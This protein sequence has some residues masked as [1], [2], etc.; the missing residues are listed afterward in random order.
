VLSNMSA[1]VLWPHTYG[2]S[3]GIIYRGKGLVAATAPWAAEG[4]PG[5]VVV[6]TPLWVAAH[7]THFTGAAPGTW[8]LLNGTGSGFLA[9]AAVGRNV[10]YVT[11]VGPPPQP[12]ADEGDQRQ[13][14]RPGRDFTLVVESMSF[15]PLH[16]DD[17][18]ADYSAAAAAAAAA[19]T[20]TATFQ[21]GGA[22]AGWAGSRLYVWHTNTTVTFEPAGSVAVGADGTFTLDVEPLAVYTVTTV[23]SSNPGAA[24]VLA[25]LGPPFAPSRVNGS[26]APP[27]VDAPFPL[28]WADDYEGYANDSLPLY[29]SDMFGAF[30]TWE[31]TPAEAA[32]VEPGAGGAGSSALAAAVAGAGASVLACADGVVAAAAAAAAGGPASAAARPGRCTRARRHQ[33]A[34][35][36]A[37]PRPTPP[38]QV[39]RQYVRQAPIGWNTAAAGMATVVGN[40]SMPPL[41]VGV[42]AL[43]ETPTPPVPGGDDMRRSVRPRG[44]AAAAAAAA[45]TAATG[46][47]SVYLCLRGGSGTAGG[48]SP[49][50]F[51]G[52]HPDAYTWRLWANGSWAVHDGGSQLAAGALPAPFGYDTW[53][54]LTF[55]DAPYSGGGGGG[56]VG[57]E[58]SGTVD[59]APAFSVRVPAPAAGGAG[60]GSVRPGGYVALGTGVNRAQWDNL[61]LTPVPPRGG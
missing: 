37:A 53:H 30:A 49:S 44:G 28:P 21:L 11:Y 7:T 33:V 24:A 23:P 18:D 26:D 57:V 51:Y 39:L 8:W 38:N 42:G 27:P 55:S 58:L 32:L 47:E 54:A 35:A 46:D 6:C 50:A 19:P 1:T 13:Q 15:G 4:Q 10:S 16:A 52:P 45:A 22:L 5:A 59:G 9:P 20:V 61:V 17:A 31:T 14:Q 29:H 60:G 12:A 36:D 56:G 41:T 43:I 34:A 3:A 2:W 48:T 40:F 25:Q